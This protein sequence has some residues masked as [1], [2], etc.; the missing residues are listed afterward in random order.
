MA[1]SIEEF[2]RLCSSVCELHDSGEYGG[3]LYNRTLDQAV[4]WIVAHPELRDQLV[5]LFVDSVE[6]RGDVPDPVIVHAMQRLRWPEVQRAAFE[7]AR[8]HDPRHMNRL[9]DILHAFE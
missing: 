1:D 5:A 2:W 8:Q 9:S 3:D 7:F 6:A 4:E